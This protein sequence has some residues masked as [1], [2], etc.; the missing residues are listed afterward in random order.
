[1]RDVRRLDA[2][3]IDRLFSGR[4][5]PDDA[6]PGFAAVA[7]L[8]SALTAPATASE[9]SRQAAAVETASAVVIASAPEPAAPVPERSFAAA[10]P[11]RRTFLKT[12]L[13]SLAFAGAVLGTS[14]LAAAGVL[15]D[16]VQHIAHRILSAVGIDVPDASVRSDQDPATD[17]GTSSTSPQ[18]DPN[19]GR[20]DTGAGAGADDRPGVD[21]D[22]NPGDGNKGGGNDDRVDKDDAPDD[23][24]GN[25]GDGDRADGDGDGDDGDDDGDDDG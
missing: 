12:K 10:R 19:G 3:T 18:Q 8:V 14:G 9:L 4:M 6:P 21:K 16:P 2:G 22:D 20:D 25:D 5:H 11:A 1:M 7:G 15:P 23:G 24:D 17:A 13:A